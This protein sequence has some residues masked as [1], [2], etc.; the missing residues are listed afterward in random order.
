MNSLN[1][2]HYR[3]FQYLFHHSQDPQGGFPIRVP[4]ETSQSNIFGK[5]YILDQPTFSILRYTLDH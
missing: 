4:Q 3:V 5:R 2:L 1:Y